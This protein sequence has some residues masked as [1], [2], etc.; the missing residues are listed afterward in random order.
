MFLFCFFFV[1][2][3]L[4]RKARG[5]YLSLFLYRDNARHTK[6]SNWQYKRPNERALIF[7][8]AFYRQSLVKFNK[9]ARC[10]PRGTERRTKKRVE[11]GGGG[12]NVSERRK[13]GKKKKTPRC[14]TV[15]F[16][17]ALTR[18]CRRSVQPEKRKTTPP[19]ARWRWRYVST[20]AKLLISQVI[21][22]RY[23]HSRYTCL[24]H[25]RPG[26][27]RFLEFPGKDA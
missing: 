7:I 17:C 12:E 5:E 8:F 15:I 13:G 20:V 1:F 23:F 25:L 9:M 19:R 11:G 26:S 16:H 4:K 6:G 3:N 2:C 10:D 21:G 18:A 24:L 14:S 22:P 27:R